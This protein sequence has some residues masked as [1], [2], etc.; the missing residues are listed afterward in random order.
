[1]AQS[2]LAVTLHFL[3]S[4]DSPGLASRVAE[5][6]GIC[7]HVRLIFVFL[8]AMGF[9]HVGQA[10]LELLSSSHP[11]SSASQSAEITGVSHCAQPQITFNIFFLFFMVCNFT[12]MYIFMDFFLLILLIIH[13]LCLLM[14]IRISSI[15]FLF[16]EME[17]HSVSQARV[18]WRALSSL[19]PPPPRFKR[20][21]CLSLLSSWD[22]RWTPQSPS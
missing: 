22:S 17:F 13:W 11:P 4:S 6:I 5:I 21:S 3:G 10:G 15:L 19:Q 7:H 2:R 14:N 18:Q 16:F 9:C 8:V 1:M 20:F 12:K